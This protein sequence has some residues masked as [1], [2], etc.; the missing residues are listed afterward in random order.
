MMAL[1][2]TTQITTLSLLSQLVEKHLGEYVEKDAQL[3]LTH[4]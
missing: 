2:E 1:P 4:W 3:F